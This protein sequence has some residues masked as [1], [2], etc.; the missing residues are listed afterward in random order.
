MPGAAEWA[1]LP[2]PSL[3]LVAPDKRAWEQEGKGR[4][5]LR[6]WAA[7]QGILA[8]R[9]SLPSAPHHMHHPGRWSRTFTCSRA[10][11]YSPV[12]WT[13]VC[14]SRTS[15][16]KPQRPRSRHRLFSSITPS[17]K[18]VAGKAGGGSSG[19][20]CPSWLQQIPQ[21]T[22]SLPKLTPPP[23][24]CPHPHCFHRPSMAPGTLVGFPQPRATSC[25]VCEFRVAGTT[26]IQ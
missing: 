10:T 22:P 15:A 3:G 25:F 4:A 11:V 14:T 23:T 17:S 19:F 13:A 7:R 8:L 16:T 12:H 1:G 18:T 2:K 6:R 9:G 20:S 24:H 26:Y 21:Q 5:C